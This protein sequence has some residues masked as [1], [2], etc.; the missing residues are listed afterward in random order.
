MIGR[1]RG[2]LLEK[3]PP[4][5]LIEVG[6]VAYELEASLPTCCSLPE[7]GTETILYTHLVVREDA[8]LLFGFLTVS[9]RSL[10][11]NLLKVSS[12]GPKL[13]LAILSGIEPAAFVQTVS[14]KD[15]LPLTR[16]PGVG[17]KTAERLIIDMRDRLQDW[18][19]EVGHI[20][21]TPPETLMHEE[22]ISALIS[23]GYKPQEAQRAVSQ[24]SQLYQNRDDIIRQALRSI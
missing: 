20:K 10:F 22:A 15:P 14:Q 21:I 19:V 6:G 5:L 13:A 9:E 3:K 18:Q 16:I 12:V 24:A 17:K 8:Q 1:L 7:I 11:R 4:Q 23:L 2:I